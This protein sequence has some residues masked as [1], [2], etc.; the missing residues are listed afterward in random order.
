MTLEQANKYALAVES[1]GRARGSPNVR[2]SAIAR[3]VASR[4]T[5]TYTRRA[6]L[7]AHLDV[8]WKL[9]DRSERNAA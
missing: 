2:A 7:A 4:S 1:W 6:D 8:L 3:S 9:A 5:A